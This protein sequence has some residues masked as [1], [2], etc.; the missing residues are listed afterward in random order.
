MVVK[1]YTTLRA[2]I[3]AALPNNSGRNID[4]VEVR[5]IGFRDTIDSLSLNSAGPIT[6]APRQNGFSPPAAVVGKWRTVSNADF[7]AGF[8]MN[9]KDYV[10]FKNCRFGEDSALVSCDHVQFINCTFDGNTGVAEPSLHVFNC[11]FITFDTVEVLNSARG[12]LRFLGTVVAGVYSCRNIVLRDVSFDGVTTAAAVMDFETTRK[13]LFESGSNHSAI[14]DIANSP[15]VGHTALNN[16]TAALELSTCSRVK[17]DGITIRNCQRTGIYVKE[18]YDVTIKEIDT[19]GIS[20]FSNNGA[21]QISDAPIVVDDSRNIIVSGG[22]IMN[23]GFYG[24]YLFE[25]VPTLVAGGLGLLQNNIL[26]EKL[27]IQHGP[28]VP[29]DDQS[30]ITT[31]SGIE[32][33]GGSEITVQNC[34]IAY[35]GETAIHQDYG[36]DRERVVNCNLHHNGQNTTLAH[37]DGI[38][39]Q[40]GFGCDFNGNTIRD[41]YRNGI[42]LKS[43]FAD[44]LGTFHNEYPLCDMLISRNVIINNTRGGSGYGIHMTAVDGVNSQASV[45]RVTVSENIIRENDF[46]NIR[47][48]HMTSHVQFVNNHIGPSIA[49]ANCQI[50][51]GS[52][53]ISFVGGFIHSGGKGEGGFYAIEAEDNNAV[54]ISPDTVHVHGVNF[55]VDLAYLNRKNMD[56][57]VD[58]APDPDNDNMKDSLVLASGIATFDIRFYKWNLEESTLTTPTVLGSGH[59]TGDTTR[60][61]NYATPTDSPAV[62]P[63]VGLHEVERMH[64]GVRIRD[65]SSATFIAATGELIDETL[66]SY[67]QSEGVNPLRPL[68]ELLFQNNGDAGESIPGEP[69]PDGPLVP[70]LTGVFAAN[71]RGPLF[72]Y[73]DGSATEVEQIDDIEDMLLRGWS[74]INTLPATGIKPIMVQITDGGTVE[75]VDALGARPV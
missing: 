31:S 57:A 73:G 30:D 75:A 32:I 45:E 69:I 66:A 7:Q 11:T 36:V 23:S 3:L 38:G 17:V 49:A 58:A 65:L 42:Q 26:I 20:V 9:G 71:G 8:G 46:G 18:S 21:G 53:D 51:Y 40:S 68:Q 62:S 64:N 63:A 70:H 12:G 47:T 50:Q 14:G 35:C 22:K 24:I 29:V 52:H 60:R 16:P 59:N 4:A 27:L 39:T 48:S 13:T 28:L 19:E 25:T 67:I 2:D 41:N 37:S 55:S 6:Y 44:I 5:D 56:L 61:P 43:G 1:D 15:P 72:S 34:E 33:F 10:I 74:A 54:G